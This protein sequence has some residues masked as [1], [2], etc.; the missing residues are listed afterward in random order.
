M[1]TP[2]E[3]LKAE[4][5]KDLKTCLLADLLVEA[6]YQLGASDLSTWPL[7]V[8]FSTWTGFGFLTAWWLGTKG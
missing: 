1:R 7:P 3:D 2:L 6:G 4:G 8:V 5:W